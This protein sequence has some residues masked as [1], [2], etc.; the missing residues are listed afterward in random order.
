ME[1]TAHTFREIRKAFLNE[2]SKDLLL[3]SLI[4]MIGLTGS[5]LVLG[6][7]FQ[8]DQVAQVPV[9]ESSEIP[10]QIKSSVSN[11]GQRQNQSFQYQEENLLVQGSMLVGDVTRITN[12]IFSTD[13]QYLIDY[14]NGIRH[15][16]TSGVMSIRYAVP[17]IY[18]LQCYV[19][20]GNE[21]KIIAAETVTIRKPQI[22]ETDVE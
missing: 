4:A 18:L 11:Q 15:Q 17:G 2:R 22:H 14:G 13:K 5:Y 21:W 8:S 10:G 19:R 7:S 6:K 20:D 12:M 16:M 3:A 9:L 1:Q